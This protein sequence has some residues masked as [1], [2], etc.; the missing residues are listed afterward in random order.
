[1]PGVGM[2]PEAEP[3]PGGA[4]RGAA[5]AVPSSR[6]GYPLI[7]RAAIPHPACSHPPPHGRC[8]LAPLTPL[9][10]SCS[11]H[12][13]AAP[14]TPPGRHGRAEQPGPR[15]RAEGLHPKNAQPTP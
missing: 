4:G 8:P 7:S 14:Q 2:G 3:E 13:R 6:E 5:G 15:G 1:M 9:P 11:P 12:P 10:H